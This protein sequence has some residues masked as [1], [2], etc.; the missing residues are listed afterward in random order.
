MSSLSTEPQRSGEA[1]TGEAGGGEDRPQCPM[2]PAMPSLGTTSAES[3]QASCLD[4]RIVTDGLCSG[5]WSVHSWDA[6]DFSRPD[7]PAKGWAQPLKKQSIGW[8]GPG[9]GKLVE[10]CLPLDFAAAWISQLVVGWV[11]CLHEAET[12]PTG[13]QFDSEILNSVSACLMLSPVQSSNRTI[14]APE[15]MMG[16]PDEAATEFELLLKWVSF[17]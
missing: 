8:L 4:P 10:F 2:L 14:K 12:H 15:G 16:G 11:P 17:F 13:A 6:A 9:W 7:P 3:C 1:L 5:P